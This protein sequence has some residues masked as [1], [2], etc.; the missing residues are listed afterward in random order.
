MT[1]VY[2]PI[3]PFAHG[4]LDAGDGHR[5]YF[6]QCG[7]PDGK[8]ALVLHGGP[9][10]GC[11][12]GHRRL[13]NP[14]AYRVVLFDQ[15]NCGRS[16]PHASA[17][18]TDLSA[19][20]TAHLLNDIEALRAHLGIARWLVLGGSWGSTLALAYALKH[21]GRVSEIVLTSITT[22]RRSDIRWLYHEAGQYFPEAW[23]RFRDGAQAGGPD[24][25]LVAAYHALL[26]HPAPSVR[27]KA[28]QDWCD[29]EAAV[30]AITPG[31]V[32]HPR[33]RDPAFRMAF[34]RTVTHYFRH[35]AWLEEG[36]LLREAHRLNGI[37]G[38][39]IHGRLD[40]STP[41]ATAEALAR[42]WTDSRLVIVGDAGHDAGA[43]G[44]RE[45]IVAALDRFAQN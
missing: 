38:V 4:M 45:N 39:L 33:Y 1:A 19:N 44:M 23:R 34:A 3:E 36:E 13:F 18:E 15:R 29:W 14:Q 27:E 21:P 28:A 2:P 9:G 41:L 7:K 43:Q 26:N 25:D 35:G 37:P 10:S 12:T 24:A 30:I 8:P 11:T 40:R 32:P 22:S 42:N 31:E 5:V 16:L 20:T 6:E 17:H